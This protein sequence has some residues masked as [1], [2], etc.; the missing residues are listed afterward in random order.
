MA[1][2]SNLSI[3]IPHIGCPHRCSF[4]DQHVISGT[5]QAPTPEAVAALCRE[6]LLHV[7]HPE[8]ME[9]AF[10]GGSFTAIP[11]D[12]RRALLECVQPFLGDGKF[13][14]IRISTRPDAITASILQE[15]CAA[16]VTAV[17][18]GAQSMVDSVLQQNQRGHTA[19]DV[20]DASRQ[21][22]QFGLELGL[23]MMIGLFG[24]TMQAEWDTLHALLACRPDTMRFYPVVVLEETELAQRYRNGSYSLY[25]M[26]QVLDFC[27]DAWVEAVHAGSRVIR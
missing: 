15:L 7:K 25:S 23:Q 5:Q 24:S 9:I 20:Q 26:E 1:K 22:Q 17:E 19:Q 27:A 10:F 18:L 3:F 2:H 8:Q 14:G 13:A 12:Y 4:C 21:I 11:A 16:G 6:T